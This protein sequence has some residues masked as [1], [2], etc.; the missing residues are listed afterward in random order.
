MKF[1]TIYSRAKARKRTG[2]QDCSAKMQK[3]DDYC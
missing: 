3:E 1:T 2:I